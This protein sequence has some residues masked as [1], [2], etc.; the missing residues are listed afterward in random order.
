VVLLTSILIGS[1]FILIVSNPYNISGTDIAFEEIDQGFYCGLT[2]RI[3]Y[4]ISENESW[5]ELWT[6]MHNIC[7]SVPNLPL[8]N[9][10]TDLI[11]AVFQGELAT[12]GY[13][14]T[15][16][17]IVRTINRYLVYVDEI[18]PGPNCGTTQALTQPYHIVR[19]TG[20]PLD[21][22]TQYVYN[23]TVYDCN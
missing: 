10:T 22:P 19:I 15:I 23:I 21:L 18:H 11:I 9:F 1:I 3:T 4:V 16:T 6:N 17:K 13:M 5:S 2:A 20:Y 8:A 14:T 12:G 7:S